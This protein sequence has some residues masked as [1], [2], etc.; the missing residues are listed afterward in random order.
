MIVISHRGYHKSFREN[1]LEAFQAAIS[2]GVHGIETDVRLS[3][4][5][6][7]ILCHDRVA[8]NGREV[9]SLTRRELGAVLGHP[10]PTLEEALDLP[11][12]ILWNIEIKIPQ[13]FS[14]AIRVLE[15]H[16][17]AGDILVTSFWHSAV[18]EHQ[19]G[20]RLS[21]GILFA[22][23][24]ASTD[25]FVATLRTIPRLAA[26]VWDYEVLDPALLPVSAGHGIRTFTYGASSMG[27][28][29]RCREIDLAGV[30][31]D[32]PEYLL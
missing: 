28:H 19:Q 7:L 26:V 20:S 29:A 25:A 2:L 31:T 3:A 6:E 30:I 11:G 14:P 24:P 12:D 8:P 23:R 16:P 9:S 15:S 18:E 21:Y 32:H 17:K 10:V 13:A 4:D 22:N 27:E 5:G 1:T